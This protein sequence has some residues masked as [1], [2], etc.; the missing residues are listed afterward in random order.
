MCMQS[1]YTVLKSCLTSVRPLKSLPVRSCP[2]VTCLPYGPPPCSHAA[3][4]P[5]TP[6]FRK[7]LGGQ[8]KQG[9]VSKRRADNESHGGVGDEER[10]GD[11]RGGAGIG[12]VEVHRGARGRRRLRWR[13]AGEGGWRRGELEG[14]QD[15]HA[16]ELQ[17]QSC[18]FLFPSRLHTWLCVI[19]LICFVV[20]LGIGQSAESTMPSS[21]PYFLLFCWTEKQDQNPLTLVWIQTNPKIN[22]DQTKVKRRYLWTKFT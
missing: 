17:F 9:R 6:R 10:G 5:S 21:S 4:A 8:Q 16:R 20:L 1:Q 12:E 7:N 3:R 2:R 13:G 11:E 15:G 19:R 22:S 18:L 14:A